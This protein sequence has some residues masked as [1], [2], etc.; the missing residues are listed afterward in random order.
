M[1]VGTVRWE[2]SNLFCIPA[3]DDMFDHAR[4]YRSFVSVSNFLHY[5]ISP[6]NEH[7]IATTRVLSFIDDRYFHGREYTQIAA[8][9]VLQILSAG[10]VWRAMVRHD[11]NV[12]PA[13]KI[14]LFFAV[15]LL[16]VNPNLLY[17][18]I[19]PFQVQHAIM[20]ILCLLAATVVAQAAASATTPDSHQE[21]LVIVAL[22]VLAVVATFTLGNAPVILI[23][24]AAMAIILRWRLRI[25]AVLAVLAIVHTVLVL[26]TTVST[27]VQSN[28]PVQIVRF[29]LFY[30]GGP[31][32][33]FDAWPGGYVTW[34]SSHLLAEGCGAVILLAAIGFSI[35]RLLKPGLGGSAAAFGLMVLVI[36]VVTG[37]AAGHARA[38]F[39]LLEGASKKY[40]SFAALGWA[41][42]AAV[43]EG[44]R[45]EWAAKRPASK[46]WLTLALLVIFVPFAVSGWNHEPRLWAKWRE[47]NW[48]AALAVFVQANDA[49]SMH[50]LDEDKDDIRVYANYA[51]Q[52]NTNVFSYFPFRYGDTVERALGSRHE[53]ACRGQVDGVQSIPAQ[54]LTDVFQVPGSVGRISG[55]TWIDADHA[56]AQ[57]VIAVDGEHRVVG[58]A[59]TVR[60]SAVAEQ[61]LGQK[62]GIDVGY[63]GFVRAQQLAGLTFYALSKSGKTYC[64]LGGENS[65]R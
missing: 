13:V 24:A 4:M 14:A 44:L 58:V 42:V 46:A 21:L 57:T 54:Q 45:R 29:A 26:K 64:V 17:T 63:A 43:C 50:A 33:R 62:F 6:H 8:T 40:A 3:Y 23:G 53:T 55:W 10:L 51:Q 56:P 19:Y 15:L 47:Q 39:G 2:L 61:W 52:L 35:A 41:G 25:V 36:V 48:E 32:V 1:T 30:L 28:N 34:S 20:A 65:A 9:N 18:L 60:T 27:G 22:L 16:F 59:R 37:L 49:D 38:Q 31:F 12:D 7:R 11:S 5:L